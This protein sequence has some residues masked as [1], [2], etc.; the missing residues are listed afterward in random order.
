MPLGIDF[1][2]CYT[3]AAVLHGDRPV[4]LHLSYDTSALRTSAFVTTSGRL[5]LG[6]E[7]DRLAVTDPGRYCTTI[8]RDLPANAPYLLGGEKHTP[9]ELLSAIL[10]VVLD[11]ARRQLGEAALDHVTITLPATLEIG[12]PGAANV[13]KAAAAAGLPLQAVSVMHEPEAAAIG[14][15]SMGDLTGAGA[16]S[17]L[18]V[19]DLG[20]GTFD[21]ALMRRTA[22]GYAQVVAPIGIDDCGGVRF[23]HALFEHCAG[24]A[25][26]TPQPAA[27]R[28]G[29]LAMLQA[30]REL[31]H[32]LSSEDEAPLGVQRPADDGPLILCREQFEQLIG[33]RIEATVDVLES[34]IRKAELK[35]ADV[36]SILL[37]G[38]S[39]RIPFVQRRLR[40]RLGIPLVMACDPARI[41]S[42]GAAI[43]AGQKVKRAKWIDT[44]ESEQSSGPTSRFAYRFGQ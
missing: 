35:T 41:V 33:P 13:S 29:L 1:G 15:L 37:V 25:A 31:K 28:A 42:A 44:P 9:V 18:L 38:G 6:Q 3:T 4:H 17:H 23:D 26:S 22:S 40:E 8:K 2:T 16:G 34:L 14:A 30:C 36:S 7:A 24:S 32:M 5:V 11:A 21:A 20:G 27:S 19:Y 43:D 12:G 10:K 39:C